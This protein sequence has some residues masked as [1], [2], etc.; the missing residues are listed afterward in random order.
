M[1]SPSSQPFSSIYPNLGTALLRMKQGNSQFASDASTKLAIQQELSIVNKE[2]SGPSAVFDELLQYVP[3]PNSDFLVF[4]ESAYEQLGVTDDVR[5][6]MGNL[7][8]GAAVKWNK[9]E[10]SQFLFLIVQDA[11]RVFLF[12]DFAV[13][14]LG[15]V[16]FSAE[17]MF[18]WTVKARS[19]VGNDAIQ[20]GLWACIKAFCGLSYLNAVKVV[21]LYRESELGD[22]RLDVPAQMIGWL[23]LSEPGG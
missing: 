22:I 4:S 7:W 9:D 16:Q 14:L 1:F 17:E 8:V 18:E 13:E 11:K 23:R 3:L 12:L 6:F 20:R 10:R 19:Q 2:S 15:Q 5:I 21:D